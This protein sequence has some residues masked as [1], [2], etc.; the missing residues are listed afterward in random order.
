MEGK[1][2]EIKEI[3]EK[4]RKWRKH[5]VSYVWLDGCSIRQNKGND[6]ISYSIV[7]PHFSCVPTQQWDS[8]YW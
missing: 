1:A 6:N 3:E 2:K 5:R 4:E 7:D 8:F